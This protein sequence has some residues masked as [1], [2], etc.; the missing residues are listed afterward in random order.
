MRAFDEPFV[1]D[2]HE[3]TIRPSVGLA[4][5]PADLAVTDALLKR[6]DTAMYSAKR[7]RSGAVHTFTPEMHRV[8]ADDRDDGVRLLDQLR[9][10]IDNMELTLVYQP[11]FDLRE[12]GIVGVEALVRW[13]HPALGVL[14]PDHFL[15]LVHRHGLVAS[16]TELVLARAL[17]DAADWRARGVGCRSR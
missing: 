11:K 5:R 17:D 8:D 9:R 13:P 12:G 3:L 16:V 4:L 2:G 15:P 14:V 10:A 7:S 6:A 1:V